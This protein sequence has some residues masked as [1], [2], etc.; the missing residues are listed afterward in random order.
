MIDRSIEMI[1]EQ[2]FVVARRASAPTSVIVLCERQRGNA[3]PSYVICVGRG[4]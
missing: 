3:R 2:R 1:E 4:M